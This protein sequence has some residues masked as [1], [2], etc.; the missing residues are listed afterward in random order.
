MLLAV[1]GAELIGH[2]GDGPAENIQVVQKQGACKLQLQLHLSVFEGVGGGHG[3]DLHAG[4]GH[5]S[6]AG[7]VPGIVRVGRAHEL[8]D[9]AINGQNTDH[10]LA[11]AI[12]M[13]GGVIGQLVRKAPDTKERIVG[14]QR[15]CRCAKAR[16][17]H[18]LFSFCLI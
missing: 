6:E 2:I 10:V 18:H 8:I 9:H 14:H 4:L 15:H 16:C 17:I 11:H 1:D 3:P 13:T 12:P 5:F 7:D